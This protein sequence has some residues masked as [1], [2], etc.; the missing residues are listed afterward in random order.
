MDVDMPIEYIISGLADILREEG[1]KILT[2]ETL[3][4]L[5]SVLDQEILMSRTVH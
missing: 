4:Q 5:K 2:L 1:F 3:I